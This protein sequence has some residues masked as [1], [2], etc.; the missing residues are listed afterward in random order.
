[1]PFKRALLSAS[2]FELSCTYRLVTQPHYQM[3]SCTHTYTHKR[4]YT[5]THAHTGSSLNHF[6]L[7]FFRHSSRLYVPLLSLTYPAHIGSPLN[8]IIKFSPAHKHTHTYTHKR[9][10]TQTHA[11][12]THKHMHAYSHTQARLANELLGA[13]ERIESLASH[14]ACLEQVLLI[15]FK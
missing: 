4:K 9:E 5:H 8:H 14:A 6:A 10:Y 13:E 15:V 12:N 11:R 1:M 7:F 2:L 3:Q